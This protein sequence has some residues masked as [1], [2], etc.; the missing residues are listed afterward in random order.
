MKPI[1]LSHHRAEDAVRCV[2]VGPLPVC[3]RCLA[4]WPLASALIVAGISGRLPPARDLEL[5][6]WL[7]PA[8]A[9]YVAVH[10]GALN[11]RPGRTWV[12]GLCLGTGLGRLF[13]RYL[14]EPGDPMVWTALG[15]VA[16]VSGSALIYQLMLK[17]REL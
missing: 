10:S 7:V 12:F 4:T 1:W 16:L 6:I 9:E 8:L 15:L 14:L 11:Y 5:A 3:R 13:H 2:R 17:K